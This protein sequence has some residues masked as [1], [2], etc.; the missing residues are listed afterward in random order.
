MPKITLSD[1]KRLGSPA[2]ILR[3]KVKHLKAETYYHL[4]FNSFS[5]FGRKLHL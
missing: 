5:A 1:P 2:L 4:D 3:L